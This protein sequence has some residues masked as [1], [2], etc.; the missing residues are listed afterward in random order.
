MNAL[1]KL[2]EWIFIALALLLPGFVTIAILFFMN[3]GQADDD[4][5]LF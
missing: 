2:S 5:N 3:V 1:R 4:W